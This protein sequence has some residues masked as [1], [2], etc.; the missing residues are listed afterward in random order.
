MPT[1]SDSLEEVLLPL[2]QTIEFTEKIEYDDD[3]LL[4]ITAFIRKKKVMIPSFVNLIIFFPK[5][6]EKQE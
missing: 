4:T 1:H 3:I 6:F 2:L 5:V